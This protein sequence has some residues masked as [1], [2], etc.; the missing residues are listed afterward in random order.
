MATEKL[1]LSCISSINQRTI[2][3]C[4]GVLTHEQLFSKKDPKEAKC[5][6]GVVD[7]LESRPQFFEKTPQTE[8]KEQNLR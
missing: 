5:T 3:K 1:K 6:Q 4:L 2:Q 8:K 7:V